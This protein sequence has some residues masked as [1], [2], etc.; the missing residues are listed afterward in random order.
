MINPGFNREVMFMLSAESGD[1]VTQ[2][3]YS[4]GGPVATNIHIVRGLARVRVI[5]CRDPRTA[6]P[7]VNLYS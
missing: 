4:T 2:G 5:K 6:V 7:R 1:Q 3:L